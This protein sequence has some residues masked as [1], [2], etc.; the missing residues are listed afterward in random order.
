MPFVHVWFS[1]KGRRRIIEGDLLESSRRELRTAA[2]RHGINLL[3]CEGVV[4]HVHILLELNQLDELPRTMNLLKGAS[5]RAIF[6]EM[7]DLKHDMHSTNF[8]Q[9][10]YASK[11]VAPPAVPIVRKYIRTQ[12]DRL[13]KYEH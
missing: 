1:T 2:D 6:L 8:W 3:E 9:A 11:V 10:G 5:A 4:D 13:E 12:W 7:P